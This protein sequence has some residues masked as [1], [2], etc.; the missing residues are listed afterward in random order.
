MKLARSLAGAAYR[1]RRTCPSRHGLRYQPVATGLS[2]ISRIGR[3]SG[4]RSA[5]TTSARASEP[6]RPPLS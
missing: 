4:V 1:T 2:R 3:R 5:F 6:P